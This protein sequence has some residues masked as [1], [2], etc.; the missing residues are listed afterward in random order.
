M[1]VPPT[2]AGREIELHW[3]S[4]L[5]VQFVEVYLVTVIVLA[6]VASLHKVKVGKCLVEFIVLQVIVSV[7]IVGKVQVKAGNLVVWLR[8]QTKL[9]VVV[10]N[11]LL[12]VEMVVQKYLVSWNSPDGVVCISH[13]VETRVGVHAVVDVVWVGVEVHSVQLDA[14]RILLNVHFLVVSQQVMQGG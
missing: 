6:D 3:F 14:G 8:V 13:S 9:L 4:I 5:A 11:V 10:V 1:E 12:C 7:L 2:I